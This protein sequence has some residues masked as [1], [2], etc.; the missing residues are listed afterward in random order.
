MSLIAN[1]YLIGTALLCICAGTLSL[2]PPA[3]ASDPEVLTHSSFEGFAEAIH[4]VEVSTDEFGQLVDVPVQLGQLVKEGDLLAQLDDRIQRAA[5]E[6]AKM[7]SMMDGEIKSA[8]AAV[9]LQE[10]RVEQLRSLHNDRM[11]GSEELRRATMELDVAKARLQIAIEQKRLRGT[12]L[13]RLQLQVEQR[14][15]RAPFDGVVAGKRL[16]AG[17]AVTPGNSAIVRLI[18]TDVLI[19]VFNVPAEASFTMQPGLAAQVYFRAARQTV[20]AEIDSVAP[21][22]NGE[23]GTVLIRVAIPNP[24]HVLRPGDRLSMRITPG[25]SLPQQPPGQAAM[26]GPQWR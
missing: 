4:D 6:V 5:A 23:S 2:T 14:Q 7:Q 10:Y 16:D 8:E 3:L 19:G 1:R 17:D 26:K 25:Q 15:I 9:S 12:E 22:I 13:N 11:A 18:R 24:D 21:A 20:D